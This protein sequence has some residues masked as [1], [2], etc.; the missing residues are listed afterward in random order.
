MANSNR[1]RRLRVRFNE[2]CRS[3][4]DSFIKNK[5]NVKTLL[6]QDL[7]LATHTM[8]AINWRV[9]KADCTLKIVIED[10]TSEIGQNLLSENQVA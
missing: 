8:G 3:T 6:L 1:F 5:L 10:Q 2:C 9:W 7:C 4:I